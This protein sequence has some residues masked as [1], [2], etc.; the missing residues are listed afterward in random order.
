MLRSIMK[1]NLD[2]L[3]TFI[4]KAGRSTYATSGVDSTSYDEGGFKILSYKEGD[5]EY[6]DTYTGFFRSRGQEVVRYKGQPVWIASYGGGMV[7]ENA[8]LA[9]ETFAFLKKAFLTDEPQFQTF[10]G[11]QNLKEGDWEYSYKQEGD[12][13]E[14]TGYEEI[15]HK[16]KLVFFHRMIGGVVKPK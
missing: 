2:Q 12:I 16:G 13:E 4:Q 8:D 14:F 5:Y 6:V 3:F 15:L 11:P 7:E 9:I 10:R 1:I